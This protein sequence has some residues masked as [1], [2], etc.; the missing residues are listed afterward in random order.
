MHRTWPLHQDRS[1]VSDDSVARSP[2]GGIAAP[3]V[4][5]LRRWLLGISPDQARFERRGFAPG[6]P[7]T[8]DRLEHVGR[9]FIRG[10]LAGLE[11]DPESAA[12]A[13]SAIAAEERGFAFEGMA[14]AFALR[15]L[16]GLGARDRFGRFLAGPAAPYAYLAHVGAGWAMARLSRRPERSGLGLDPLLYWLAI[17][18]FGFHEGY[19]AWRRTITAGRRPVW[20]QGY[21]ARAFDQ[22]VG[23]SLWFFE[24]GDPA[25]VGARI[26]T[27]DAARRSDLWSGIGLAAAY[28]GGA[29]ADGLRAVRR[30]AGGHGPA[31][32]Q[33][34]AFA[35]KAR[36]R[37]GNPAAHTALACELLVGCTAASAARM[38]DEALARL[39]PDGDVPAY[40]IWRQRIRAAV[41]ADGNS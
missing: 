34:A 35:A 2:R 22:G 1:I 17:D 28:A 15:D 4:R 33:G 18:G 23:R 5:M 6:A 31:L 30:A 37:A 14:M 21:A 26:A 3:A 19:F 29:S 40:E 38:T 10:Y 24:C 39:P 25:R 20:I 13:L 36:A 7:A 27:F 11:C 41:R 12:F 8:R 9:T 16:I 32:A